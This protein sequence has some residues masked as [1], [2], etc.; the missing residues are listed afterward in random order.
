MKKWLVT[1]SIIVIAGSAICLPVRAELKIE[2]GPS[3]QSV[4]AWWID[5]GGRRAFGT[6]PEVK[7]GEM[8]DG[9]LL[10]SP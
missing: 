5:I 2:R 10:I 7:L 4:E 1:A 8:K 6:V 9:L 3:A